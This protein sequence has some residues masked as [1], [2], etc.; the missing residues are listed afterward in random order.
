[1]ILRRRKH[2][3]KRKRL[4]GVVDLGGWIGWDDPLFGGVPIF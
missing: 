3:T 4:L 2:E 1:M